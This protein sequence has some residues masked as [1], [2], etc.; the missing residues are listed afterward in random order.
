METTAANL[1]EHIFGRI[2]QCCH[3]GMH[4]SAVVAIWNGQ[5]DAYLARVMCI[6][7]AACH[8]N[9]DILASR[10]EVQG[11]HRYKNRKKR[12]KLTVAKEMLPAFKTSYDTLRSRHE[13]GHIMIQPQIIR[14]DAA[15]GHPAPPNAS[16]PAQTRDQLY[17][18]SIAAAT[19]AFHLEMA[20]LLPLPAPQ[21]PRP[22]DLPHLLPN[23]P[24]RVI[25]QHYLH[26]RTND[27]HRMSPEP[28]CCAI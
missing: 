1:G 22:D 28:G 15:R 23:L 27:I 25:L 3:C 17:A 16:Q 14:D 13:Q 7:N 6:G 5:G 11:R 2:F 4:N 21:P 19:R 20:K 9:A 18:E 24:A 12:L 10:R 8:R 26:M